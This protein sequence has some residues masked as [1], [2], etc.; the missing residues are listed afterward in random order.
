MTGTGLPYTVEG[1]RYRTKGPLLI[2]IHVLV[3]LIVIEL[4][5][6]FII[7]VEEP[8]KNVND[9]QAASILS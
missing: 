2:E 9:R 6:S 5:L 4:W 7:F 3:I 8:D 1:F